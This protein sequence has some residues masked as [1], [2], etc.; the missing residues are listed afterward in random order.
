MLYQIRSK[1]P[2]LPATGNSHWFI[3]VIE[4]QSHLI[5]KIQTPYQFHSKDSILTGRWA[6]L[7]GLASE[8]GFVLKSE[9]KEAVESL[10]KRRDVFGVLPTGFGK[11]LIFQLFVLA[12]NRVSNSP[13]APVERPTIV[14][15]CPLKSIME[16]Q[17]TLNEFSLSATEL[18]FDGEILDSIRNGEVQVGYATAEQVLKEQ[19]T[20]LLKEDCPFH[21]S[22]SLIVVDESHTVYTW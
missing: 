21:R 20:T 10:L 15:I 1:L 6:T 7:D 19:F 17:I 9:Q 4:C 22:F 14:I 12:K 3:S 8:L 16:E 11:S 2:V 18:C 13:N 5:K